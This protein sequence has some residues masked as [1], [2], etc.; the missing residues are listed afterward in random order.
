[1]S[2][3]VLSIRGS[4]ILTEWLPCASTRDTELAPALGNETVDLV[5]C[6][7]CLS[8]EVHGKVETNVLTTGSPARM[9]N[10]ALNAA[11][12]PDTKPLR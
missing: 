7:E 10:R 4:L 11:A 12:F 5:I 8:V 2:C 9:F 3:C 1:M 6:F